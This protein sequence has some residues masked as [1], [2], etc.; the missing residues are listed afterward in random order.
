MTNEQM[1]SYTEILTIINNMELQYKEKV[2]KKL[3]DFFERNKL[4]EYVFYIDF[5]K[6]LKEQKFSEKTL[7]LLAMIN[8]NYWCES[9]EEKQALLDLYNENDRKK[10]EKEEL[11][12]K[13][14]IEQSEIIENTETTC[15]DMIVLESEERD[16]FGCIIEKIKSFFRKKK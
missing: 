3:I 10:I 16:W 15:Y 5:T 11:L 8:L 14:D 9:K 12:E 6:P 7:P 13:T 4:K 1:K 2:P